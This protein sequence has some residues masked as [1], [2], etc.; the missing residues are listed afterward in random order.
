[1]RTQIQPE[2]LVLHIRS[3]VI[4]FDD[5]ETTS[6]VHLFCCIK[7]FRVSSSSVF[8]G[9]KPKL[10]RPLLTCWHGLPDLGLMGVWARVNRCRVC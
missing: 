9:V 10:G 4:G 6:G 2:C 3:C 8:D 7:V 5:V 1:M